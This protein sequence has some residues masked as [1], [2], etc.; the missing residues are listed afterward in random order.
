[1]DYAELLDR[2][3]ER[4]RA[5]YE[6]NSDSVFLSYCY[7]SQLESTQQLAEKLRQGMAPAELSEFLRAELPR[8]K[9]ALRDEEE[10]PSFDWYDEHYRCKLLIGQID[11]YKA[12]LQILE[13]S[14]AE[15]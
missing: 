11:A 3:T 2:E 8:L 13:G 4:C 7:H 1:M 6:A 12:V 15:L 5:L 14:S 10:H 9:Q